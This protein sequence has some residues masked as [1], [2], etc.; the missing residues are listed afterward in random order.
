MINS[1]PYCVV[2]ELYFTF[3]DLHLI[4]SFF[5]TQ[6]CTGIMEKIK[7]TFNEFVL[8]FNHRMEGFEGQLQKTTT[9]GSKVESL[10]ADFSTFKAFMITILRALQH[11]IEWIAKEVVQIQM[12]G[13]R[14]ILLLHGVKVNCIICGRHLLLPQDGS[15]RKH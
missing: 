3:T 6:H 5:L 9:P 10:T 15:F 7:Q 4:H 14:K 8:N 2:L 12:Q 13:R 11:Q 1:V